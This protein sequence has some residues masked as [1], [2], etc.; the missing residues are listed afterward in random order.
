MEVCR[1]M[2]EEFHILKW[3]KETRFLSRIEILIYLH[4]QYNFIA[5]LRGDTRNSELIKESF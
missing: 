5:Q 1:E 3:A 2:Y 4:Q